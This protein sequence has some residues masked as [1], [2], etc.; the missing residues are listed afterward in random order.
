MPGS[1][2]QSISS[3]A[4]MPALAP[5]SAAPAERMSLPR[6]LERI[7]VLDILRGI[8][9]IGMFLVHF[10]Y[11]EATPPGVEPGR[12]AHFIEQFLGVFIEERFY[13]MFAMLFGV[14]F[15]VQLTRAEARGEPFVGR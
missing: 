10:N 5:A 12:L 11:Y 13:A 3:T 1:H 6:V 2:D 8:A 14:G 4:P 9:L 7:E 15:A